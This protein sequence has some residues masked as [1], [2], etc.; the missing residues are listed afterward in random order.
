MRHDV[1][2]N[3]VA[4]APDGLWLATADSHGTILIWDQATGRVRAI[5]RVDGALSDCDWS[6]S[7]R[8]IAAAGRAGWYSFT[9]TP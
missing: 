7:G 5:M 8:S 9:F 6:L 1:D 2:V 4:I 3:A